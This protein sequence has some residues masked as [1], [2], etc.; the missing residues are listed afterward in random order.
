MNCLQL[1]GL[2]VVPRSDVCPMT[3]LPMAAHILPGFFFNTE[4]ML[5][6]WWLPLLVQLLKSAGTSASLLPNSSGFIFYC[7]HPQTALRS[8]K[9]PRQIWVMTHHELQLLWGNSFVWCLINRNSFKFY[10]VGFAF[11]PQM[12]DKIIRTLWRKVCRA[13]FSKVGLFLVLAF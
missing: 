13:N 4:S 12:C 1:G 6:L 5:S 3:E 11:L 10:F 2:R 9:A 8:H 7:L